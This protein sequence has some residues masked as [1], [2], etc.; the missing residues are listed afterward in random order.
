MVASMTNESAQRRE[1][2][3]LTEQFSDRC[4][5]EFSIL[6]RARGGAQLLCYSETEDAMVVVI[7][8]SLDFIQG[9]LVGRIEE[10]G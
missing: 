3:N 10:A 1:I 6:F 4:Q 8:G 7:E 2:E 5:C 9:Y